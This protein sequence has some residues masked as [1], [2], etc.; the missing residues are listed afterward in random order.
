MRNAASIR[1]AGTLR[2]LGRPIKFAGAEQ[3]ALR[4][5]PSLGEHGAAL[6]REELGLSEAEIATLRSQGV[7]RG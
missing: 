2:L 5:P 1:A 7:I 3:A 4:P 6:L